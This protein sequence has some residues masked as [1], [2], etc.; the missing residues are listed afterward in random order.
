MDS[1]L[2]STSTKMDEPKIAINDSESSSQPFLV[3]YDQGVYDL[4]NFAHKHPGGRNTL[5]GLQN[6]DIAQRLQA[7]PPHSKAA[8]YLMKEYRVAN[9]SDLNNNT[10]QSDTHLSPPHL[11][12]EEDDDKL[13]PQNDESM[14]VIKAKVEHKICF[15]KYKLN[16]RRE[17]EAY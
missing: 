15:R 6:R 1:H 13:R 3:Y 16:F 14:E 7:A 8:M 2:E 10:N 4:T 17:E 12:L 9:K 11:P 5:S